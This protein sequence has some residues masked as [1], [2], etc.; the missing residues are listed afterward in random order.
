MQTVKVKILTW[1]KENYGLFDYESTEITKKKI[2][3]N[4]MGTMTR[5]GKKLEFVHEDLSSKNSIKKS[6]STI[7]MIT[8]DNKNQNSMLFSIY[9]SEC[10][11]IWKK[12]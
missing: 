9:Q 11:I 8:I 1:K 2:S 6:E 4:K 3:I 7:N 5:N 12:K 10:N